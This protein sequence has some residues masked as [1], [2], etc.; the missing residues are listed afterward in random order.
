MEHSDIIVFITLVA[1]AT[2]QT[3]KVIILYNERVDQQ[4]CAQK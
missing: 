4:N 2:S 3:V 1:K